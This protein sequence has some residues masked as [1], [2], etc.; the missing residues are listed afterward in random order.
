MPTGI[1][2]IARPGEPKLFRLQQTETVLDLKL[3]YFSP[4]SFGGLADYAGAQ[5]EALAEAGAEVTFLCAPDFPKNENSNCRRLPL[6]L[7]HETGRKRNR[8][9]RG[10]RMGRGILENHRILRREIIKGDFKNVL[11]AAYAE[12]LDRKSTRLNSSHVAISYAVFC[13]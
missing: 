11:F 12:Y 4:C 1:M 3:L 6:L 2:S 10:Y 5:S 7:P 13:L 8:L 9:V